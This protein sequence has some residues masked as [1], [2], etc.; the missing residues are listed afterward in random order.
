M[1]INDGFEYI[2]NIE[3]TYAEELGKRVFRDIDIE[4]LFIKH[5][6]DSEKYI[7]LKTNPMPGRNMAEK[8]Q[9]VKFFENEVI[10][11]SFKRICGERYRIL[12]YKFVLGV[13]TSYMPD[14]VRAELGGKAQANLGKYI[15]PDKRLMTYFNGID[16]HQ[17]IIDFPSRTPDFATF[18]YYL[19]NVSFMESPLVVLKDSHKF[20]PMV[21]PHEIEIKNDKIFLNDEIFEEE[22]LNGRPGDLFV[23]HPYILHGTYP[24]HDG[25]PRVSLRV[26]VER[27][28]DLVTKCE[29]CNVNE[30]LIN[31]RAQK[32]VRDMASNYKPSKLANIKEMLIEKYSKDI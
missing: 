10:T 28:A 9:I 21:F 17:D 7:N 20:G 29:L 5:K 4:N 15:K 25:K 24:T 27:N 3:T 23:W 2:G 26:L 30:S 16:F 12:D 6:K 8:M 18:Y 1:F 32:I 31:S 11:N 14:W 19:T 13:P 22:I